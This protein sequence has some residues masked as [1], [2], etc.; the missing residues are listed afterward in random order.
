MDP[1]FLLSPSRQ[2]SLRDD[3]SRFSRPTGVLQGLK[4]T[5]SSAYTETRL[6]LSIFR[7]LREGGALACD[8]AETTR[9][10]LRRLIA[11]ITPRIQPEW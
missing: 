8:L 3:T 9:P 4:N 5:E 11:S 10:L 6:C 2:E 1:L 7:G